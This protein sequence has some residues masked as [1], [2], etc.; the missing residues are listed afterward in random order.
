MCP[1]YSPWTV[2][3]VGAMI[4]ERDDAL[5]RDALA[6]REAALLRERM[7]ASEAPGVP[8]G[9]ECRDATIRLLE[10]RI[11]ELE[12]RPV[13]VPDLTAS[14]LDDAWLKSD[15]DLEEEQFY[16]AGVRDGYKIA[17]Y[18]IQP[19]PADRV[20]GDGGVAVDR[21]ELEAYRAF[22][23]DWRDPKTRSIHDWNNSLREKAHKIDALRAQAGEV[24][25]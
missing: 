23:D 10:S 14:D 25:R 11:A 12:A 21:V 6:E 15:Y 20:L 5:G 2:E 4:R 13:V 1:E 7:E 8:D 3:Q 24:G 9:I 19:I 16:H 18:R 22:V 17:I